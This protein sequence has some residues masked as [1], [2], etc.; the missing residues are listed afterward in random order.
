MKPSHAS[1]GQGNLI[2]L[3]SKRDTLSSPGPTFVTDW[4]Y[5]P[6]VFKRYITEPNDLNR[7]AGPITNFGMTVFVVSTWSIHECSVYRQWQDI[8]RNTYNV[9]FQ[10]VQVKWT[11]VSSSRPTVWILNFSFYWRSRAKKNPIPPSCP[12]VWTTDLMQNAA[13]SLS[14][15]Q[16]KITLTAPKN[17]YLHP[18]FCVMAAIKMLHISKKL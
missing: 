1:Q 6:W 2:F 13:L 3:G 9:G 8:T 16:T 17:I 12:C 18:L 4:L 5:M 14:T 15:L 11:E 7:T 10:H